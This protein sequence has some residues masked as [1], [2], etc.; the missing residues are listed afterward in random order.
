MM[1]FTNTMDTPNVAP[2]TWLPQRR[3]QVWQALRTDNA[4]AFQHL[5][6]TQQ[7]VHDAATQM[8]NPV[9]NRVR[10]L[11]DVVASIRPHINDG[12]PA[13]TCL[14]WLMA[15]HGDAYSREDILWVIQRNEQSDMEGYAAINAVL[16]AY[17]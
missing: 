5:F 1:T 4:S 8:W 3:N 11:I 12:Q 15:T 14:Q 6:P 13:L 10:P 9:H 2:T 17:V 7:T 16:Q